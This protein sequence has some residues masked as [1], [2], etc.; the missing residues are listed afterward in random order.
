MVKILAREAGWNFKE[1]TGPQPLYTQQNEEQQVLSDMTCTLYL[2]E[3]MNF[4]GILLLLSPDLVS[5]ISFQLRRSS[6]QGGLGSSLLYPR[7]LELSLVYTWLGPQQ[8]LDEGRN[9]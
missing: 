4:T 2:P 6:V 1:G 7:C 8:T 3:N 9:E 5:L